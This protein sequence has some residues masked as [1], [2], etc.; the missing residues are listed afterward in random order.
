LK[1]EGGSE[2]TASDVTGEM[3]YSFV[4]IDGTGKGSY[5]YKDGSNYIEELNSFNYVK[6]TV[7]KTIATSNCE[8]EG[9]PVKTFN[10][11][12]TTNKM[13]WDFPDLISSKYYS[14]DIV[15]NE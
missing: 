4:T 10:Y 3:Y 6:N 14:F 1:K 9:F 2:A 11:N 12:I 7:N 8:D 15:N 5:R 13:S